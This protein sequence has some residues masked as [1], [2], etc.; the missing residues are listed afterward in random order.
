VEIWCGRHQAQIPIT[1][2]RLRVID[3]D[4]ESDLNA[5]L[6][7]REFDLVIHCA[8]LT[9]AFDERQYWVM[10]VEATS[11][12]AHAVHQNGCRDFVYISTRCAT[13]D[14]GAYGASKLGAEEELQKLDWRSLLIIR[15]AEIY[16]ASSRE[17][18]DQ[19]IAVA[20]KWRIVPALFGKSDLQFAPLHI[21][22]FGKLAVDLISRLQ[23]GVKIE[24]LCGPEDLTG[25]DLARRISRRCQAVP[26]PLWWPLAVVS[27]KT[28]SLFG[29][30]IIKP[31][32]LKRLSARKTATAESS[33]T[34]RAGLRRFLKEQTK[35][36]RR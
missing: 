20:H 27:F 2:D 5:A 12:L 9:H 1:D 29:F 4:L 34:N 8:A 35:T 19:M 36:P 24:H 18:L 30:A 28:L 3:L 16:G 17:G 13:V 6:S 33:K 23:G 26:I 25:F 22:D 15:P 32:Q 14:A 10:N 7:G 31:D 21:D 11:R